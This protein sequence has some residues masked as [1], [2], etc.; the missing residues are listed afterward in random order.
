MVGSRR[1]DDRDRNRDETDRYKVKVLL[2]GR[3]LLREPVVEHHNELEPEERLDARKNHT[4]LP[5][6]IVCGLG[7]RQ[8]F[9][10][11]LLRGHALDHPRETRRTRAGDG[12]DARELCFGRLSYCR[13]LPC[14]R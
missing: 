8:L 12:L 3:E 4:T 2:P 5:E 11:V 6:E 13:Q 14:G 9:G 1:H 7:E 10:L